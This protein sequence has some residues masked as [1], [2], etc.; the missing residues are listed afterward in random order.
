MDAGRPSSRSMDS[1]SVDSRAPIT[2]NDKKKSAST[3]GTAM[4]VKRFSMALRSAALAKKKDRRGSQSTKSF[5]AVLEGPISEYV[6]LATGRA[7]V[8]KKPSVRAATLSQLDK[9]SKRKSLEK[10][11]TRTS[12]AL[13]AGRPTLIRGEPMDGPPN[14][15]DR[16]MFMLD[17][18]KWLAPWLRFHQFKMFGRLEPEVVENLS[19]EL[20]MRRFKKGELIFMQGEVGYH[21]FIVYEGAVDF[22]IQEEEH[23][24]IERIQTYEEWKGTISLLGGHLGK[25]VGRAGIGKGFGELAL[26]QAAARRNASAVAAHDDTV[27]VVMSKKIYDRYVVEDES[28]QLHETAKYIHSLGPFTG[29]NA[30]R[31]L[32]LGYSLKRHRFPRNYRLF[33]EGQEADQIYFLRSGQVKLLKKTENEPK[34]VP[35]VSA[36]HHVAVGAGA[37]DGRHWGVG[38]PRPPQETVAAQARFARYFHHKARLP[39]RVHQP[40]IPGRM[41]AGE[42][43]AEQAGPQTVTQSSAASSRELVLLGENAILGLDDVIRACEVGTEAKV[44]YSYSAVSTSDINVLSLH[45]RNF[46][47]FIAQA[48]DSGTYVKLQGEASQQRQLRENMATMRVKSAKTMSAAL[49]ASEVKDKQTQMVEQLIAIRE[50]AAKESTASGFK[51]VTQAACGSEQ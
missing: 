43:T 36:T 18:S 45:R 24:A 34:K 10:I 22:F 13:V 38:K 15:V 29:W 49:A 35:R 25:K 21:F 5:D 3:L 27:L 41:P 44:A 8:K 6:T 2:A 51:C 9:E 4:A 50:A 32:R 37:K 42:L 46:G 23:E 48:Q 12:L 28:Q 40:T 19:F 47:A 31:V 17:R 20:K 30:K 7:K 1:E 26:Q 11:M 14:I 33:R 16:R 39:R